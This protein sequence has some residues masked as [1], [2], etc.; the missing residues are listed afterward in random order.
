MTSSDGPSHG[1]L[2]GLT[3]LALVGFACNSLLG[4]AALRTGAIDPVSLTAVRLGSGALVLALLSRRS[5]LRQRDGLSALLLLAYALPF[6][7][8]YVELE[9]GMGAL[10]L[11]GAVQ[12]TML[13]WSAVRGERPPPR[14][15]VGAALAFAGL[16]VLVAPGLS[17]PPPGASVLMLS[18]GVAWG[19]YTLRGRG[20][21][22][23]L[24]ATASNF[25]LASV[26]ALLAAAA[27]HALGAA[28]AS[29]RGLV[30]AALSGALASGVG[31]S[32]WYAALPRLTRV[33]AAVVQLLVPPLAGLGGVLLLSEALTFRLVGGGVVTLAGIALATLRRPAAVDGGSATAR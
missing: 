29:E 10:L 18:A 2:A 20:R 8:A 28:H 22:G 27:N 26:P 9:A 11:F 13:L 4:R 24:H 7:L 33:S 31:Y 32:L 19:A 14:V 25:A 17:A 21:A 23:P 16:L 5:P 12:T 15:W 30:L 6:S 1:R 3:L